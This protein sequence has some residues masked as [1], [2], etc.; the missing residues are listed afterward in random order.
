MSSPST[1]SPASSATRLGDVDVVWVL[2]PLGS[3]PQ[4]LTPSARAE[5]AGSA[6][7]A[8]RWGAGEGGPTQPYALAAHGGDVHVQRRGRK[9]R[10]ASSCH[11]P[12][13]RGFD[14]A[15]A[16]VRSSDVPDVLGRAPGT[17]G[18]QPET[19]GEVPHKIQLMPEAVSKR[20][21]RSEVNRFLILTSELSRSQLHHRR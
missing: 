16:L 3:H 4:H 20:P 11:L 1:S 9:D 6:L 8:S 13:G 10:A 15:S 12:G 19:L 5:P 14:R 18:E 17:P 21:H 2:L 7:A